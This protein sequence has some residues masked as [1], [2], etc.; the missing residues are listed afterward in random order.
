MADRVLSVGAPFLLAPGVTVKHRSHHIP[1]RS[2]RCTMTSPILWARIS[3]KNSDAGD[4][5]VEIGQRQSQ[6]SGFS[7]SLFLFSASLA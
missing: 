7:H 5:L 2:T 4:A 6:G 1:H 3:P